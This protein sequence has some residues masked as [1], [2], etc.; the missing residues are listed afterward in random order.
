MADDSDPKTPGKGVRVALGVAAAICLY[1]ALSLVQSISPGLSGVGAIAAAFAVMLGA[2]FLHD[3]R[4]APWLGLSV[5]V[6]ACSVLNSFL[7][8]SGRGFVILMFTL[9]S[10][11]LV[12][13][14][15]GSENEPVD[16]QARTF[17]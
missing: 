2:K 1:A 14:A 8:S 17:G 13:L 10:A 3:R 6:G 5:G 7:Q 12:A 4:R 9:F 15:L 16:H 11:I